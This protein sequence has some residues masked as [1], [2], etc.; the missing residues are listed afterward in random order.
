MHSKKKIKLFFYIAFTIILMNIQV[1]ISLKS[2][3]IPEKFYSWGDNLWD[4]LGRDQKEFIQNRFQC[5]GFSDV[6]DRPGG[7][8]L[9]KSNSC[10]KILHGMTLSM[11][12]LI[13]KTLIFLF[14]TES[15]GIGIISSLKLRK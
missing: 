10:Y 9:Y 8:C 5:C 13:E 1:M 7:V 15:T 12:S 4:T 2:S 14:L 6:N 3:L 11:R